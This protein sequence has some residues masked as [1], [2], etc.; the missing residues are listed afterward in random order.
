MKTVK[1]KAAIWD[2][3]LSEVLARPSEV[4]TSVFSHDF[5]DAL[6][7]QKHGKGCFGTGTGEHLRFGRH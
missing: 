7:N 1:M 5:P 2:S 6:L 4:L 3:L